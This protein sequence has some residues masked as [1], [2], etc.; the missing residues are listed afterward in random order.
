[1]SI[2]KIYDIIKQYLE[3]AGSMNGGLRGGYRCYDAPA[4]LINAELY[5]F[6]VPLWVGRENCFLTHAAA[7]MVV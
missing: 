3:I 1:M 4:V 7:E 5:F 6:G 2:F